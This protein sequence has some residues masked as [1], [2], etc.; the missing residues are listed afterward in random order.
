VRDGGIRRWFIAPWFIAPSF[1]APWFTAPRSRKHSD[2]CSDGS[3][4]RLVFPQP[5]DRPAGL[6]ERGVGGSIA[7]DILLKLRLPVPRIGRWLAT[8]L[9]ARMP[10]AAVN[11]HRDSPRR[12]ND[13]WPN[14]HPV[15]QVQPKILPVPVSHGMQRTPKRELR[16]GVDPPVSL[17]VR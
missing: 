17:H 2:H 11:E 14:S 15:I 1:T 7:F 3:I 8:V 12:E 16:L 4:E 13:V 6:A 10:E 9:G 5:Y